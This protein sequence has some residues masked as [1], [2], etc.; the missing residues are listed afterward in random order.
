MCGGGSYINHTTTQSLKHMH[1]HTQL[2]SGLMALKVAQSEG[3]QDICDILLQFY[4]Q[5]GPKVITPEH[6]ENGS[7]ELTWVGMDDNWR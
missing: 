3:Y 7:T 1:A 6:E 2:Q 4:T 5:Q